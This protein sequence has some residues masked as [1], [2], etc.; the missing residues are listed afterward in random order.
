M[1]KLFCRFGAIA[2]T[3]FFASILASPA[4]A[5][6][7]V[8]IGIIKTTS[9]GPIYIAVEKG[10]FAAAGI[11]PELIF[12]DAAQ[13]VAV[14]T[15]SGDVDVGS[16][17]LTAGFYTFASQGAVKI[18]GGQGREAPGF[19]NLGYF[20]SNR[21]YDAGFKSLKDMAGH[22]VALSQTGSP[23]H[24]VVGALAEKYGIS[25]ADIKVVSLQSVPNI[26]SALTGGQVDAGVTVV[27]VPVMPSIARGD[28]H[29]LRWIGD[30]LAFQDRAIF[31]TTK[32]ANERRA[33]LTRFLAAFRKGTAD[34]RAAFIGPNDQPQEG[35]TAPEMLSI[36]GK[37]VGQPPDSI[38]LG[39][40]YVDG[41]L[42]VNTQDILHQIAWYKSQGMLKGDVSPAQIFDANFVVPLDHK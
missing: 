18:I 20:V 39:L 1:G 15:V 22:T 35:P 14:A 31:V 4:H 27:T 33:L 42:R 30:E 25:F 29:V 8:K 9:S 40:A 12:F 13:P 23:G 37:Y 28:L 34:Y 19:H 41:Q 21:A 5:A 36:I 38:K 16:T 26:F 3:L 24:Y 32:T 7:H 2:L 10:Y 17:G 6:D 11:D